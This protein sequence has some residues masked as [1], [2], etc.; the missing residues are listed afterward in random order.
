VLQKFACCVVSL[1][2][3]SRRTLVNWYEFAST[4]TGT[5]EWNLEQLVFHHPLEVL[6]EV[7]IYKEYIEG[8][9]MIAYKYIALIIIYVLA[10]F[11]FYWKEQ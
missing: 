4:T 1:L 3:L 11:Y 2:D 5:K 6:V 9:L 8:S 7:A 10:T